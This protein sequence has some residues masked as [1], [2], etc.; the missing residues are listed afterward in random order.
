MYLSHSPDNFKLLL[1]DHTAIYEIDAFKFLPGQ[2]QFN[3]CS[4]NLAQSSSP[5]FIQSLR[6]I[7]KVEK[8]EHRLVH[9]LSS[10]LVA[11]S[12]PLLESIAMDHNVLEAASEEPLPADIGI[13]S[14]LQNS[15]R[16]ICPTNEANRSRLIGAEVKYRS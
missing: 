6:L 5:R 1:E 10:R 4:R 9:P 13:L 8:D 15:G 16:K 11:H 12:K 2:S 14:L 3:G 7:E